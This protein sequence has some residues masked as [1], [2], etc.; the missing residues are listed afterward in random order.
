MSLS[1]TSL[2]SPVDG[3]VI[4]GAGQPVHEGEVVAKGAPIVTIVSTEKRHGQ[5]FWVTGA[6][7]ELYAAQVHEGQPV[8]V[9][10]EAFHGRRFTGTVEQVGGA[11]EATGTDSNQ[12]MLQQVPLRVAFDPK[13]APV[14]PGMT[15]RLW[16][17]TR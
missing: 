12:W 1:D 17:T 6:V 16:I 4:R 13:E 10:L 15:G 3:I 7:S 8:L 9:E 5:S 2:R 11:M 14:K